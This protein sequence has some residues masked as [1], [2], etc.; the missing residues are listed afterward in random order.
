MAEEE[1]K[2]EGA[3]AEADD[4]VAEGAAADAEAPSEEVTEDVESGSPLSESLAKH[5]K[6]FDGLY[7]NM[8]RAGEAGGVL[9]VILSRLAGFME[10]AARLKK[11]IKG[12][13]D[14]E[15]AKLYD[16]IVGPGG[17]NPRAALNMNGVQTVLKIRSQYGEP[18]KQMGPPSKYV[19]LSFYERALGKK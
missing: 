2:V 14:E 7:T 5:P 13:S 16:R 19:D 10:K 3:S 1:E 4:V 11:R 12:A 18:R 8:V 6:V 9:D 15:L 17:L